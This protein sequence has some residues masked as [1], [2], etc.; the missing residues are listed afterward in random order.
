MIKFQTNHSKIFETFTR[1]Q[2]VDLTTKNITFNYHN[3][4]IE[5][6]NF[7]N[8]SNLVEFFNLIATSRSNDGKIEF[9]SVLESKLYPIYLVQFHPEFNNFPPLP[10]Y[11]VVNTTENELIA[12]ACADY[13][14]KEGR[15][16]MNYFGYL[17]DM[18]GYQGMET[19][20][21]VYTKEYGDCYVRY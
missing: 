15:K 13:L 5:P 8:S 1:E 12:T 9:I 20:D 6:E 16:N 18:V 10:I 7:Y 2:N 11:K 14:I 3:W 21:L 17:G 4:M 19:Y